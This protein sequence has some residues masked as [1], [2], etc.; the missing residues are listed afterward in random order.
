MARFRAGVDPGP[1]GSNWYRLTPNLAGSYVSGTWSA[2]T[3]DAYT[4]AGYSS[5]I[6]TN[7]KVFIAG[8]DLRV[9]F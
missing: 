9:R 8:A 7:G 1:G 3:P 2:F 4:R 6:L 5:D